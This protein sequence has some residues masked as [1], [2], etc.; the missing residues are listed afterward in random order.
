[1]ATNIAS[2]PCRIEWPGRK[3]PT[4]LESTD[5]EKI[6]EIL[7]SASTWPSSIICDWPN[8][9][10]VFEHLAL[11]VHQHIEEININGVA[12]HAA[13]NFD[14]TP[15]LVPSVDDDGVEVL[16]SGFSYWLP[17][18]PCAFYQHEAIL[19]F[20]DLFWVRTVGDLETRTISVGRFTDE[21]AGLKAAVDAS[22]YCTLSK[23]GDVY[24][25]LDEW[26]Q[27]K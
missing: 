7:E 9:I 16:A 18:G 11:L 27:E 19:K 8:V 21:A 5:I 22:V 14:G 1:M 3:K 20:N 10:D 24:C 12:V 6:G 2:A 23:D 4:N 26:P 13:V 17:G 25:E 15:A